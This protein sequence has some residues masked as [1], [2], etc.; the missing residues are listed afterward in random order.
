MNPEIIYNN[1][2]KPKIYEK[3]KITDMFKI[4]QDKTLSEE[5]K[6]ELID[7][8]MEKN[9]LYKSIDY[10]FSVKVVFTS[11]PIKIKGGNIFHTLSSL[12]NSF[13][14]D[15]KC[16]KK[17]DAETTFLKDLLEIFKKLPPKKLIEIKSLVN[18]PTTN[19]TNPKTPMDIAEGCNNQEMIDFI[20]DVN[21]TEI[22]TPSMDV[23]I[24]TPSMDVSMPTP[25]M[26]VSM[27]TSVRTP[28][29]EPNV[30]VLTLSGDNTVTP[31]VDSIDTR[32]ADVS[33]DNFTIN[34]TVMSRLSTTA[35]YNLLSESSNEDSKNEYSNEKLKKSIWPIRVQIATLVLIIIDKTI[36]NDIKNQLIKY[37]FKRLS[38]IKSLYGQNFYHFYAIG[39][40]EHYGT[41]RVAKM[42]YALGNKSFVKQKHKADFE[43]IYKY[44]NEHLHELS[45]SNFVNKNMATAQDNFKYTPWDYVLIISNTTK[46]VPQSWHLFEESKTA[47][48]TISHETLIQRDEPKQQ[49]HLFSQYPVRHAGARFKQKTKK[50]RNIHSISKHPKKPNNTTHRK[51]HRTKKHKK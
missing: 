31:T 40:V 45:L 36:K 19:K 10:E 37:F 2:V 47:V 23:S 3:F 1:Q 44:I 8:L 29:L 32:T 4:V 33:V 28:E 27:P 11:L 41:G 51:K 50:S 43:T 22:P 20:N 35:E 26:D 21:T 9:G 42:A 12:S 7:Q 18:Q 39:Y 16:A 15:N 6:I 48:E 38:E 13:D 49:R 14:K 46:K 25:S 24:P 5:R 34:D 17:S 30:G